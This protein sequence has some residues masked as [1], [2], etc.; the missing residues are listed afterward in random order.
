MRMVTF[1]FCL[2][3]ILITVRN[4]TTNLNLDLKI[5][6]PMVLVDLIY[7]KR[8][9]Y[10][11]LGSARMS[12][13]ILKDNLPPSGIWKVAVA[14]LCIICSICVSFVSVACDCCVNFIA[15]TFYNLSKDF[16]SCVH[17]NSRDRE[18]LE[19]VIF[20]CFY[21]TKNLVN[22]ELTNFPKLN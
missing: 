13:S 17:G 6:S 20:L 9:F 12:P 4:A 10:M 2:G 11:I 3:F 21:R 8:Q 22:F 5:L 1:V 19:K 15:W 18:G 16:W 7:E 14:V